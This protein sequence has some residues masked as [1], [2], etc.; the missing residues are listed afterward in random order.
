MAKQEQWAVNP[1][2]LDILRKLARRKAELA[3]SPENRERRRLWL[4]HNGLHGERPMVLV[5]PWMAFDA[6]FD[7]KK[8]LQCSEEWARG[9]ERGM[10]WENWRFE[11]VRDDAVVEPC[12]NCG[13]KVNA[14]DFGV[15]V[16]K[17]R[18]QAAD[19]MMGSY[20]WDAPIKNIGR[21]FH[22][23]KPRTFS[24][25]REKTLEWKSHLEGIFDGILKVRMR[26][27]YWWTLGMT[28]QVIELI[29]L[30]NLMLFMYDDPDGLHKIMTFV[31]DENL[32]F[33]AWLEKEGL[34]TLNNENDYIGSGTLGYT[35]SLP[36]DGYVAEKPA[37]MKD[38]WVLLESQET[39]GVGPE[40]FERFVFP[41]QLSVA[42]KFGLVY[43]G[44]CEPVHT[45]WH[46]L[47]KLPNL[48]SV[49][50][51]PWCN[52]EFMAAALG[53]KYVFSRK[54]NPAM[55]ST[56]KFDED[57]IRRDLRRT[58]EIARDCELEIIMKDIHTLAGQPMRVARWVELAREEIDKCR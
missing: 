49:S 17:T 11:N 48:R 18:G 20:V 52:Q 16:P 25:D 57:F 12:V 44:C 41:Y 46:V 45:R 15:T 34:M 4:K 21:D 43:Y 55:I 28:G 13:W 8:E 29:G 26:S 33:A 27:G 14:G 40:Q 37:R 6:I 58:L 32:K 54:P 36:A 2:D 47:K 1:N 10:R 56:A 42:E 5:E 31:R 3:E 24:V 53:R 9:L 38:Q 19:G 23:L 22:K 35:T 39:V 30:E 51:S 7:N 50:V